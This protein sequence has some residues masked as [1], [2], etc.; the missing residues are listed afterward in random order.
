[1]DRPIQVGDLAVL[2]Y[3]CCNDRLGLVGSV[4]GFYRGRIWAGDVLRCNLCRA[5]IT[6]PDRNSV[7]LSGAP[8]YWPLA[9][10]KKLDPPAELE[11]EKRDE[12]V[13]L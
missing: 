3:S 1:M 9:W 2:I 13:F 10:V 7:R 5:D 11:G 12:E 6:P 8:D 4:N